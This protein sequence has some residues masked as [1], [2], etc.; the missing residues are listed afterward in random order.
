MKS[1]A[2]REEPMGLGWLGRCV[3]EEGSGWA[4]KEGMREE[5]REGHCCRV[6]EG[7]TA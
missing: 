7:G 6:R 1:G 2:Q 4:L 5:I 3:K